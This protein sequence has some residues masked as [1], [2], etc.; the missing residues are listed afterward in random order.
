MHCVETKKKRT[1]LMSLIIL[2]ILNLLIFNIHF[3]FAEEEVILPD[4]V[5]S[6]EVF[7]PIE[8]AKSCYSDAVDLAALTLLLQGG[9]INAVSDDINSISLD[10]DEELFEIFYGYYFGDKTL[11]STEEVEDE[12]GNYINDLFLDCMDSNDFNEQGYTVT[13]SLPVTHITINEAN[14]FTT[15][16]INLEVTD[17]E[18]NT[19]TLDFVEHNVDVWLGYI[20]EAADKIIDAHIEDPESVNKELISEYNSLKLSILKEIPED[21]NTIIYSITDVKSNVDGIPAVFMF[22]ATIGLSEEII[23]EH[24][25]EEATK[26]ALYKL[27]L[28]GLNLGLDNEIISFGLQGGTINVYVAYAGENLLNELDMVKEE[29]ID[30]VNFEL[31]VCMNSNDIDIGNLE[32]ETIVNFNDNYIYFETLFD[33]DDVEIITDT[34][35]SARLGYVREAMNEILS[36]QQVIGA[37]ISESVLNKYPD[38]RFDLVKLDTNSQIYYVE[39]TKFSG[40]DDIPSLYL[41]GAISEKSD[42]VCKDSDSDNYYDKDECS[43]LVEE[44]ELDCDD[45]NKDINPDAIEVCDGMDNNCNLAKDEGCSCDHGQIQEVQCGDGVCHNANGV[46]ECV[47][48]Q[49]DPPACVAKLENQVDENTFDVCSDGLDN[50]CD[51][52]TDALDDDCNPD[53]DEDGYDSIEFGGD[54]CDDE[55]DYVYSDA[56]EICENDVDDDC[57]DDVDEED[58]FDPH[59]VIDLDDIPVE[60]THECDLDY[61]ECSEDLTGEM[62]CEEYGEDCTYIE[63]YECDYGEECD[64][65]T[66]TCGG[67]GIGCEDE[68]AIGDEGCTDDLLSEWFCVEGTEGCTIKL[69]FPCAYGQECNHLTNHCEESAEGEAEGEG[70]CEDECSFGEQG[71]TEDLSAEWFCGYDSSDCTEKLDFPCDDGQKCNSETG[72]CEDVG[73]EDLCENE[74]A[75]EE[76]GCSD[77]LLEE[78]TCIAMPDGCNDKSGVACD[79]GQQCNAETGV[80]EEVV[81]CVPKTCADLGKE[82]DS[83]DDACDSLVDCGGCD[84]GKECSDGKCVLTCVAKTCS[85]LAKDCG[86]HSDGCEGSVDCG[87]CLSSQ[88]C[89]DGKCRDLVGDNYKKIKCKDLPEQT[90][91]AFVEQRPGEKNLYDYVDFDKYIIK[92]LKRTKDNNAAARAMCRSASIS[93]K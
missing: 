67:S 87:G 47:F 71:C 54:D 56:E 79:D 36:Q 32:P 43:G 53:K 9:R 51:G 29:F 31:L 64:P 35:H 40:D 93:K 19:Q 61:A 17:V 42:A 49:W 3:V 52:L 60:C 84:S 6:E 22:G 72:A 78:W 83:H 14:V 86:S 44:D 55:K 65:E 8:T 15:T 85:D 58:C 5:D 39:D 37:S 74:C 89:E 88:E 21:E 45:D 69:D 25:H 77:D 62:Y 26:H 41:F 13:Y 80:C 34:T 57:D 81:S 30:Y 91:D 50:D 10:I 38:L 59:Q 1:V 11:P 75:L 46:L 27:M 92:K 76:Q 82:C 4:E 63:Y 2:L 7:A 20:Y 90:G 70:E 18:E 23:V 73:V 33:L 48:G 16:E 28:Q 68:C 66:G 24:C 12:L